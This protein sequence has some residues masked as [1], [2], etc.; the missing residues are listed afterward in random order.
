MDNFGHSMCDLGQ[1]LSFLEHLHGQAEPHVHFVGF[2]DDVKSSASLHKFSKLSDIE[3]KAM[4]LNKENVGIFAVVNKTDGH[5]TKDK[6]V[7]G[8]NALFIDQEHFCFPKEWPL[9]PSAIVRSGNGFHAYWFLQPGE[10]ISRFEEIQKLLSLFY[11]SDPKVSNLARLMRLPGFFHLKDPKNPKRVEIIELSG[12]RYLLDEVEF[13]H[14]AVLNGGKRLSKEQLKFLK[15][16]QEAKAPEGARNDALTKLLREGLAKN[17]DEI[18]LQG[19]CKV[20]CMRTSLELE[21]AFRCLKYQTRYHAAKPFEEFGHDKKNN[22]QLSIRCLKDI[23]RKNMEFVVPGLIPKGLLSAFTGRGGI[24]KS[25]FLTALSAAI[26]TGGDF[27]GHRLQKGNVV[28]LNTDDDP[29]MTIANRFD[30]FE[31]DEGNLFIIDE[32]LNLDTRSGRDIDYERI[33]EII[34]K[35][36]P[37]VFVIDP[38]M[39]Q[40]GQGTGSNEATEIYPRLKRLND[41]ARE[42]SVAILVIRHVTKTPPLDPA[43]AG[44]GS[45]A[46]TNA[47]RSEVLCFCHPE[48]ELLRVIMPTKANDYFMDRSEC[49]GFRIDKNGK[50]TL[51]K[52]KEDGVRLY[53][54]AVFSEEV[55]EEQRSQKPSPKESVK[56]E[57]RE[58]LFAIFENVKEIESPVLLNEMKENGFGEKYTRAG[59]KEMVSFGLLENKR[60][61]IEGGK[62]GEAYWVYRRVDEKFFAKLNEMR[63]AKES[64]TF[65]LLDD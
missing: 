39:A 31:K 53:R 49:F 52:I 47:V 41:L 14:L 26:S 20:F 6:N 51:E 23:A 42:Y 11:G 2:R 29:E 48:D 40:L 10:N 4:Q 35:Y 32:A 64:G 58:K 56:D 17:F 24:G 36:K 44:S 28:Y 38:I 18:F 25:Y 19:I 59:L 37:T 34:V 62:R 15:W 22:S 3:I 54:R 1:T 45:A 13:A 33:E 65:P 61:P 57:V 27:Y 55:Q 50:F 43:N 60:V 5:G 21:E 9:S 16:V 46:F 63:Q 30:R 12:K 7:I 8:L